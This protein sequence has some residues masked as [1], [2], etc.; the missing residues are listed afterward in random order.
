MD[1]YSY[2]MSMHVVWCEL[3]AGKETMQRSSTPLLKRSLA[4]GGDNGRK[5]RVRMTEEQPTLEV[6]SIQKHID[7][8]LGIDHRVIPLYDILRAKIDIIICDPTKLLVDVVCSLR[9]DSNINWV[10]IMKHEKNHE[11]NWNKIRDNWKQYV[12]SGLAPK[13]RFRHGGDKTSIRARGEK[14]TAIVQ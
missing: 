2:G 9:H 10:D 7:S 5:K 1:H 11:D 8:D 14:Q 12:I 3:Q 6:R 4:D 13:N